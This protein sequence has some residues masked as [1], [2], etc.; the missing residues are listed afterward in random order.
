MLFV[1]MFQAPAILFVVS[2]NIESWSPY[3][4]QDV[5]PNNLESMTLK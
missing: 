5:L 3:N 1:P 2:P 4:A